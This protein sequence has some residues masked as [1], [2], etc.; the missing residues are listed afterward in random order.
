MIIYQNVLL[1]GVVLLAF[2]VIGYAIAAFQYHDLLISKKKTA[3]DFQRGIVKGKISEQLAAYLPDWPKDLNP[4]EA[5]FL[6][7]PVDF[8]VFKGLD[9]KNISEVV[10]VEVKSGRKYPNSN[11]DSLRE[12]VEQKRVRY[13]PFHIPTEVFKN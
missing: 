11:E 12:T 6:G 4:S 10:F 13:V 2:M 3:L 1:Y 7:D 5:K 9:D 8:I